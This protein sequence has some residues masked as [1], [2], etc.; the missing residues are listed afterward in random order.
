MT[1]NEHGT[2]CWF[3]LNVRDFDGAVDFYSSVFSLDTHVMADVENFRYTTLVIEGIEV[4]GVLD[5][6][7]RL[8]E[9]VAPYWVVYWHVND[10]DVALARLCQLGGA[11]HDGPTDSPFGRIAMVADPT[12]AMFKLRGV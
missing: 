3:E 6:S 4:A 9:G 12:G 11:V 10:I 7:Q 1:L 8:V 2:P 5:A